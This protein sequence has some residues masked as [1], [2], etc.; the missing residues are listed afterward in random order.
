MDMDADRL[1]ALEE[2]LRMLEG[3]PR[4][5]YGKYRGVVIDNQGDPAD[6]GRLKVRVPEIHGEDAAWAW[7]CVPYAG[8]QVGW[9][10]L[11]PVG[12]GVWVEFEAGDPSKPI[13]VGCFWGSGELP[14]DAQAPDIRLLQTEQAQIK[15]DD[16]SGEVLMK[17][18]NNA[19]VTWSDEVKTEAGG[20]TH[21]VGASGV[22]S[23]SPPGKV[24]VGASGVTV[25]NG[26]FKVS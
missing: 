15:I 16:Q 12:A 5:A 1:A 19:T 13:W 10:V 24:E 6:A 2:R 3:F 17:N 11:P 21:T 7:P 9:F 22:V 14:S 23:E 26:A 4:R 8:S 18:Q 25:N 20:A